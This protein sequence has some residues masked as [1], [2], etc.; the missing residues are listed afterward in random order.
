MAD[1]K[2][3]LLD[4]KEE[5]ESARPSVSAS[6]GA[7]RRRSLPQEVLTVRR[8]D[9]GVARR[10]VRIVLLLRNS[11]VIRSRLGGG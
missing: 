4:L 5:S 1:L 10:V 9:L 8:L 2:L 11:L 6:S 3:A 7:R